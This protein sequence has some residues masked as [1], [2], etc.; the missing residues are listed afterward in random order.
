MKLAQRLIAGLISVVAPGLRGAI[1]EL[2]Q[3]CGSYAQPIDILVVPAGDWRLGG[4]AGPA[5][6]SSRRSGPRI[7]PLVNLRMAIGKKKPAGTVV[8]ICR[9][10][11]KAEFRRI[12]R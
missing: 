5:T 2:P 7:A 10:I 9:Q 4:K 11:I 1:A 8:V 6:F 3:G 12:A